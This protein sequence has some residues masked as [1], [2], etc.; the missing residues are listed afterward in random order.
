MASELG[1]DKGR[2]GLLE[3]PENDVEPAAFTLLVGISGA[4]L[5]GTDC[6]DEM[7]SLAVQV[8]ASNTGL[9]MNGRAVADGTF[10]G[11]RAGAIDVAVVFA[12][13]LAEDT[14]VLLSSVL[15][16]VLFVHARLFEDLGDFTCTDGIVVVTLLGTGWLLDGREG[17]LLGEELFEGR[18]VMLKPLN[19]PKK[20]L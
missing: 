14:V 6:I 11:G 8:V 9:L 2:V 18:G 16:T 5:L 7:S 17:N 3:E 4:G 15:P 19:C 1:E 13:E 10:A 12:E 20:L